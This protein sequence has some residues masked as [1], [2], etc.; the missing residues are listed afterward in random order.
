MGI[1]KSNLPADLTLVGSCAMRN[2]AGRVRPRGGGG[3]RTASVI[4][5][6]R[7]P[8][9]PHCTPKGRPE[10]VWPPRTPST[11]TADGHPN[12]PHLPTASARMERCPWPELAHISHIGPAFGFYITW[13]LPLAL[14][15]IAVHHLWHWPDPRADGLRLPRHG[16]TFK[17]KKG[18]Q[19]TTS[20]MENSF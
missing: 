8:R 9:D 17:N 6:C 14:L 13:L 12:C 18:P 15:Q 10:G 7:P 16:G 4:S 1:H 3:W 2:L 5:P 20:A 11:S 19:F